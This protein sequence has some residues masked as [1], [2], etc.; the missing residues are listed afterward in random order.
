MDRK[1]C[2]QND[3]TIDGMEFASW[4]SKGVPSPYHVVNMTV[5]RSRLAGYNLTEAEKTQLPDLMAGYC[6]LVDEMGLIGYGDSEF[7]ALTDLFENHRVPINHQTEG[8]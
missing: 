7:E 1:D 6:R 3:F 2:T 4:Y 8:E 5:A